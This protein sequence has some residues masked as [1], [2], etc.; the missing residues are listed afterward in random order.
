MFPKFV[1]RSLVAVTVLTMLSTTAAADTFGT[2][3]NQFTIDFV[4]IGDA[5]NTGDTAEAGYGGVG[6]AY[7]IGT[8][9]VTINQFT[10]AYN[11]DNSIGDGDEDYWGSYGTGAPATYV[12][13]HEA[14]RFCNWLTTGDADLGYY[15]TGGS[16]DDT[17]DH[18]L[19]H[20][21]YAD[22][23]GLTYFIPTEDEWYK[24]AYYKG[25]GTDAGYW[26]YPTQHDTTSSPGIDGID[27][28]GDTDPG[29]FDAVFYDGYNQGHPNDVGNSGVGS[30][31][32]TYG[33]GGNVWEWNE[34]VIGSSR[35]LRGG[36]WYILGSDYLHASNRSS[37]Y[38]ADEGYNV[39]FR[40]ASVPEPGSITLLLCGL[41]G[42]LLWRRR[43]R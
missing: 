33:Q 15:S 32:G 5:G 23:N 37:Y 38:P 19:S 43:R 41:V 24:A 26:D 6:Y 3:G 9:E 12:Y 20:K 22:A 25:G 10:K 30:A 18:G 11:A 34:A 4:P 35:G 31:Y 28:S 42:V 39:G 29:D 8:Y 7:R 21:Q 36:D 40:V 17:P 27:S 13:W 16:Y 14:A 1:F 2:G